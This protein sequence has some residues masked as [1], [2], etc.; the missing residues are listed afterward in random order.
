LVMT[1]WVATLSETLKCG[2]HY[3]S[4]LIMTFSQLVN[5]NHFN[6]FS[7]VTTR[8]EFV[9]CCGADGDPSGVD[10]L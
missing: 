5:I 3:F 9:L 8:T 7:D 4:L 1:E 6:S 10:A 2:N